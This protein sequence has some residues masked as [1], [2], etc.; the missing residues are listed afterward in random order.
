MA[1]KTNTKIAY[2]TKDGTVKEHNYFRVTA[3]VGT[4]ANGK[5]IRKQFIG[6]HKDDAI[7]KRDD[8]LANLKR[9]LSVGFDKLSFAD[10]FAAWF[11]DVHSRKLQ[12]SSRRRY[13]IDIK[14]RIEPSTLMQMKLS[15]IKSLH[16]Q[17]HYNQLSD[18]GTSV[19]SI[20]NTHKLL[21]CFFTYCE[22]Q[23]MVVKSPLR[24][25]AVT[26]PERKE[27]KADKKEFLTETDIAMVFEDAQNNPSSFIFVFLMF[28]G[29]RV[30]EASALTFKDINFT[31]NMIS[32]SKSVGYLTID[33]EY[34]PV[35]S[36]TKTKGSTREIPI[37]PEIRGLLKRH[38]KLEQE[39]YSECGMLLFSKENILFSSTTCTYL[40]GR[41]VRRSW[42]RLCKRLYI[43]ETTV[44]ALRHTFCSLLA[45]NGVSI[46]A[47][48]E[49][50]GHS[51]I[52]ITQ[53]VY[54][55]IRTE[56]KIR[57]VAS[58]SSVV[59]RRTQAQ[60]Y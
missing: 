3:T 42:E 39:K 37:S 50:M 24:K 5:P 10:C 52:K 32:V 1:R 27:I 40:N 44:H 13:L 49:L 48:S 46:Q 47:A 57:A 6:T 26:L 31:T 54:T 8:Y 21:R 17:R 60:A 55:H 43:E 22:A 11:E 59:P 30:G 2:T 41:N 33:G 15:E 4:D 28:T 35:I 36:T 16:I 25:G 51:N 14:H 56:E 23:D 19:D 53:S 45:A 9:G 34:K 38:I 7:K 18:A 29:L 20:R 58:L 12:L